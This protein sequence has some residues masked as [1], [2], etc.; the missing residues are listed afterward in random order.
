MFV[1]GDIVYAANADANGVAPFPCVADAV[2]IAAYPM[3]AA[4]LLALSGRRARRSIGDLIDAG[5]ISISAGLVVWVFLMEPYTTDST[6]TTF[7]RIVSLAYP[8]GDIILAA[9]LSWLV[10]SKAQKNASLNWL[11]VSVGALFVADVIYEM[12]LLDGSYTL[13]WTDGGFILSYLAV[14]AAALHPSMRTIGRKTTTSVSTISRGRLVLLA[15][16]SILGPALVAVSATRDRGIDLW[17]LAGGTLALFLLTFLRMAGLVRSVERNA[18]HLKALEETR[19]HLME[20]VHEAGEKE[21]TSLALDLH[22]GPIQHL[23]ALSFE[24]E[25]ASLSVA[26][27]DAA[28]IDSKFKVVED[29]LAAE[30]DSL[31]LL[32][33]SLRPPALDERGLEQALSDL[34]DAFSIRT[35]IECRLDLHLASRLS[36]EFET[37]LFRIAQEALTNVAKHSSAKH[38]TV[39]CWSEREVR[40]EITDDGVGFDPLTTDMTGRNGHLGL[41]S[42]KERIGYS[43]GTSSIES[44]VGKGTWVSVTLAPE[45]IADA[46]ATR[47]AS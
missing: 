34:V 9:T 6:L 28:E 13:G 2:Y 12:R 44:K 36:A 47:I 37:V 25:M 21:R 7:Q 16:A 29:G 17:V 4:G 19:S 15:L 40:M 38:A 32:M 43:E 30:I 22:D 14:G 5:I 42:I 41:A 18:S 27:G 8:M 33:T 1:V 24:L 45:R 39:S 35:E 31:R 46:E 10:V 23:T 11:L 3:L 20:A 26:T